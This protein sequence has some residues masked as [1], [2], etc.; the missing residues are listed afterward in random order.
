M[1]LKLSPSEC[2]VAGYLTLR[3][4]EQISGEQ[5][6]EACAASNGPYLL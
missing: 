2:L 4:C 1:E 5:D 6:E 3:Q